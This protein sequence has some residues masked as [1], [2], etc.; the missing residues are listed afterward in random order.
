MVFNIYQLIINT[1]YVAFKLYIKKPVLKSGKVWQYGQPKGEICNTDM[2]TAGA[3]A[4][5]FSP[6][7]ARRLPEINR[8]KRMC[9]TENLCYNNE[10]N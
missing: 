9:E 10:A 1:D 5:C 8:Q 3:A 4:A 6:M 2:A 7:K